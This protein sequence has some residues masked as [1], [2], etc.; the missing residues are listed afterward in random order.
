[1][2]ACLAACFYGDPAPTAVVDGRGYAVSVS[3]GLVLRDVD[4]SPYARIQ[5][6]DDPSAFLDD[7]AYSLRDVDPADFL[8]VRAKP[9]MRDGAGSWGDFIGLMGGGQDPDLCAYF[10]RLPPTWC[11]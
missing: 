4:L 3:R 8:V 2:G 10:A 7:Q 9:G 6:A 11:E 5:R 1:L